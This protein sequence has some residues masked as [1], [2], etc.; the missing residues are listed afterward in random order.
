MPDRVQESLDYLQFCRNKCQHLI[1]GLTE[2]GLTVRWINERK[3]Y[4]FLE[5]LIYNMRHMQHHAAQLNLLLRQGINYAPPMG[6][7]YE[8][9]FVCFVN[10]LRET[11]YLFSQ[12]GLA[13]TTD[14]SI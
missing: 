1:T 6:I 8:I 10:K 9:G 5:I 4:S 3:N 13:N 2:E 11:I 12:S 7:S 14:V